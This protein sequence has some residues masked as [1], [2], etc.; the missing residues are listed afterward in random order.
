M[1]NYQ[2]MFTTLILIAIKR[3]QLSEKEFT[4]MEN[5]ANKTDDDEEEEEFEDDDEETDENEDNDR[6][7]EYDLEAL[8]DK[9]KYYLFWW[10]IFLMNKLEREACAKA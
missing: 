4:K 3:M 7:L 1:S 5:L 9:R 2:E 6:S 8:E 10:R